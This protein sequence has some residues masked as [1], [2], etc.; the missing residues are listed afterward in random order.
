MTYHCCGLRPL[1]R[2]LSVT[3]L[4]GDITPT[5]HTVLFR[6]VT[7]QDLHKLFGIL[8]SGDTSLLLVMCLF[9]L[10]FVAASS[11][12]TLNCGY[13]SGPCSL[14][15]ARTDPD[16]AIRGTFG[17]APV[18]PGHAPAFGF[19]GESRFRR[20]RAPGFRPRHPL[21]FPLFSNDQRFLGFTLSPFSSDPHTVCTLVP[22][23]TSCHAEVEEGARAACQVLPLRSR[24]TWNRLLHPPS[25]PAWTAHGRAVRAGPAGTGPGVRQGLPEAALP[26]Q[27]LA[28][29]PRDCESFSA[30]V[31][32]CVLI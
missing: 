22:A 3:I 27:C 17:V 11:A 2:P 9:Y 16:W 30:S 32:L 6:Q 20:R 23:V 29:S 18:S 4:H 31:R 14:F 19:P 24:G 28:L 13:N 10:L 21:A 7:E 1:A 26:F 15:V 25:V 8:L 12:F 5:T